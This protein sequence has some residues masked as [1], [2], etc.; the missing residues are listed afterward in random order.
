MT[1]IELRT[2]KEKKLFNFVFVISLASWIA[3]VVSLIGIA[4]GLFFGLFLFVTHALMIAYIKGH[5]LKLSENQYPEIYQR[6]VKASRQL[7]LKT[8]PEIYI[9]QEGGALNA[10]ATKLTGRNF[11]VIYSDLLEACGEEGKELDMIIG[12]EIG[13]LALGHL[14]WMWF[15]V[16]GHLIPLLGTAYSRAC[17]YSCDLC[18]LETAG[19]IDSA[20][21]GLVIL[22]AGGK[23][24]KGANLE[25]FVKQAQESGSFWS[26]IF[27]LNSTHPYT[28]K[29]IAALLNHQRPGAVPIASRPF[30]AYPLAPF[31]GLASAGSGA[32]PLVMVAI[33][34]ILAAIAIPQ[35]AQY[36]QRANEAAMTT[37]LEEV[38]TSARARFEQSGTWPCTPEELNLSPTTMALLDQKHWELVTDCEENIAALKYQENNQDQY[39]TVSF[40][41][42][43]EQSGTN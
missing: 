9:M 26:S 11:V 14:K 29:R 19:D 39:R 7:G 30:L 42:G 25:Y 28:P 21:R 3:L 4:Y 35:F 23:Y 18:G 40:T 37:T 10:F 43:E 5:A 20:S 17:E 27:E 12:H 2:K 24:G 33:I 22:S 6:F 13:H 36:R 8:T 15:L 38:Q 16:P 31:F 32:A 1:A 41:D 34:G